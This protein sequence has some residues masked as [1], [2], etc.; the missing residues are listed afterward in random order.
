MNSQNIENKIINFIKSK[1]TFETPWV[2]YDIISKKFNDISD[3]DIIILTLVENY[4]ISFHLDP[5]KE[6]DFTQNILIND[7]LFSDE[8]YR[9]EIGQKYINKNIEE[10]IAGYKELMEIYVQNEDYEKAAY[11]RDLITEVK[12]LNNLK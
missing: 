10:G 11:Y 3:L 9:N 8:K 5:A 4:T 2:S 6:Y 12:K 1:M 7:L